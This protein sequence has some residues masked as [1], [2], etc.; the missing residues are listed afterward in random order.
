MS[1]LQASLKL[2]L[3]TDQVPSALVQDSDLAKLFVL[4]FL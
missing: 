4:S 3:S 1:T 2:I